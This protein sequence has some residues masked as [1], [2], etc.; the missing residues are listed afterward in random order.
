MNKVKWILKNGNQIIECTMFPAA[1]QEM[2][3]IVKKTIA[4]GGNVGMVKSSLQII[5]PPN[6][7]G[8]PMKYNYS[9]AIELAKVMGIVDNDNNFNAKAAFGTKSKVRKFY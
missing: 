6:A 1:V 8:E 7:K 5:G 4:N 9:N 2:L 3:R